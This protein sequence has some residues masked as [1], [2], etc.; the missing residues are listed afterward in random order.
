MDLNIVYF[1]SY[2]HTRIFTI[3]GIKATY[4][5]FGEKY[6]RYPDVE[7]EIVCGDMHFT[8]LPPRSEILE[9]YQISEKEYNEIVSELEG[10][11]SFGRCRMCD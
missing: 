5:D 7:S 1:E 9:K 10:N 2:C 3:N 11:L 8:G 6:D 4:E